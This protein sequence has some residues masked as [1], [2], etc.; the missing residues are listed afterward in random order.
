MITEPR[1][2]CP[3]NR[4]VEVL[5]DRWS[6]LILRDIAW[7]NRRSFN[8]LLFG[9]DEGISAPLLARRLADLTKVG[10]LTK[11]QT[12]RGKQG[13]YSLTELGIATVPL[14]VELGRLGSLIDPSTDSPELAAC[15]DSRP[16]RAQMDELRRIHLERPPEAQ[17]TAA[18]VFS[19]SG[20]H[21]T[22]PQSGEDS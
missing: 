4:C 22:T 13:Q 9:S 3:V 14:L 17:S 7:K 12:P 2:N 15:G 5:G 1:S 20:S 8:E 11:S 18:S 10:F 21:S 19:S 16:V 6:L